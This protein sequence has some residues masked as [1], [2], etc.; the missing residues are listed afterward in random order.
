ME[1]TKES[2][3]IYEGK[4]ITLLRDEVILE[5]GR[6]TVREVVLHKGSVVVIPYDEKEK[7]IYFVKQYRY[8]LKSYL[9]EL[10]AG[11]LEDGESPYDAANRE[12]SEEIG[13]FSNNLKKLKSIASSPGFVNEVLHVFIARELV[14]RKNDKDY[15]EDIETVKVKVEDLKRFLLEQDIID[16]KTLASFFL[17]ELVEGENILSF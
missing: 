7:S 12:L 1:K 14:K 10:P 6:E 2:R 4:I 5:S 15:D 9:V 8:P 17:W 16:G 11:K 13:F 3:L